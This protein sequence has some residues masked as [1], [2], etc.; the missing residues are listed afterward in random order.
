M[1][2]DRKVACKACN[3]ARFQPKGRPVLVDSPHFAPPP[4]FSSHYSCHIPKIPGLA[5]QGASVICGI[6]CTDEK[7]SMEESGCICAEKRND[8]YGD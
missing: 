1:Y 6:C 8:G 3:D 2:K 5:G 4:F 7:D